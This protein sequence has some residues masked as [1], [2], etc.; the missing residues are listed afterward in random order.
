[1]VGGIQP[2]HYCLPVLKR[3][4]H[5]RALIAAATSGNPR[6]FA[7]TDSAPHP[8]SEKESACGCAG[9]FNAPY[10]I[11]TYARIF[12]E[13]GVLD[14]LEGFASEHGAHFYGLPLNEET[15]TLRRSDAVVPDR[16]DG[17]L[18]PFMAGEMPGWS[19]D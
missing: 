12:E 3:E 5:R 15:I 16:L 14:R 10:A 9:I 7:G 2:H 19:L 4:S 8:K 6:F 17:D 1:M 18:V 13:D 11:E